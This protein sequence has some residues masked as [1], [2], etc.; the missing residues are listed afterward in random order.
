[1]P[2]LVQGRGGM[3]HPWVLLRGRGGVGSIAALRGPVQ[4]AGLPRLGPAGTGRREE[5][6]TR[7]AGKARGGAWGRSSGPGPVLPQL[8]LRPQGCEDPWGDP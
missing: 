1:M 4:R 3:G 5:A 2:R 8:H 6:A 7:M